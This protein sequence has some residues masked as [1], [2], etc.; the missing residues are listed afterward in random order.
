MRLLIEAD[1]VHMQ[2]ASQSRASETLHDH[3]AECCIC[4]GKGEIEQILDELIHEIQLKLQSDGDGDHR[5][6]GDQQK[7]MRCQSKPPGTT[8]G[9]GAHHGPPSM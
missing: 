2:A 5:S 3:F 6:K 7:E 4:R 1:D 9:G 8:G